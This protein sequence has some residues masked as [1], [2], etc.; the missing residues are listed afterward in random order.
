MWYFL[1]DHSLLFWSHLLC[2]DIIIRTSCTNSSS[3]LNHSFL[4]SF[5]HLLRNVLGLL[6]ARNSFKVLSRWITPMIFLDYLLWAEWRR[7]TGPQFAELN[8]SLRFSKICSLKS[9]IT[10]LCIVFTSPLLHCVLNYWR[11]FF[12]DK[13]YFFQNLGSSSIEMKLPRMATTMTI[14]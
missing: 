12:K 7:T 14:L 11:D 8:S 13:S 9:Q 4:L 1:G 6:N 3:S 5:L 10:V 2:Q